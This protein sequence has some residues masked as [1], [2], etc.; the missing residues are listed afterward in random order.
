MK[1]RIC[2]PYLQRPLLKNN[3]AFYDDAVAD[4]RTFLRPELKS[5]FQF[6]DLSFY[7]PHGVEIFT[8]AGS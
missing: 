7:R 8:S 1:L 2:A 5:N 4:V 6:A 3:Q